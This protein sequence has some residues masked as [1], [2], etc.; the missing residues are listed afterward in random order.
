MV[1]EQDRAIMKG[2]SQSIDMCVISLNINRDKA[3]GVLD[4]VSRSDSTAEVFVTETDDDII[5]FLV[6]E[7]PGTRWNRVVD[8]GLIAVFSKYRRSFAVNCSSW[9]ISVRDPLL[10]ERICP[11]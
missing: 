1:K 11:L 6:L 8:I 3:Q 2:L 4:W 10:G 7:W 5:G 9:L